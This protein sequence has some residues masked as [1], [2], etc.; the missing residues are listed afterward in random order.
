LERTKAGLV[1]RLHLRIDVQEFIHPDGR[2]LLFHVPSRP[3]GMPIGYKGAYWMRSG[4]DLAPMTPDML[5]R[6]FAEAAPDFSAEICPGADMDALSP[7]CLARLRAM[8]KRKSGSQRPSA[9]SDEQLLRDAELLQPEGL[10]YAAIVLLGTRSSVGR[11][12]AC[13]EIVFEYRAS[14]ASGPAQERRE[15]RLAGSVFIRQYRRRLEVT[16]PGG[17]PTGVNEQNILWRQWPRNRRIAETLSKCGLVERSG[18]GVRRMFEEAIKESKARPDFTGTDEYQVRLTLRGEVQD[19]AFLRFLERVG[20]EKV[21]SFSTEHLLLLDLI[22]REQP[23]PQELRPYLATLQDE[24]IVERLGHGKGIRYIL[25]RR[26]YGFIGKEGVYTRKRGLDY[27][28]NKALLLRHIE[29]NAERGSPL[30]DLLQV[31]PALTRRQV[32]RL[33]ADLRAEGRAQ[34]V[35]RTRTAKWYPVPPPAGIAPE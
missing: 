34:C 30:A 10:T 22:N 26:F 11:H 6:I 14:D 31:L 20:K 35:G 29:N 18:Q 28:T 9:P 32:Q 1:D 27:E 19:P 21:A 3:V 5:R 33:L 13:A 25:S 4:Q 2:I 17:F 23:F 16:S 24:G 7:D 8:W 12:L 15:Y